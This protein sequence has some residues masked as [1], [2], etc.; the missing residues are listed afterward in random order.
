MVNGNHLQGMMKWIQED[1]ERD[2]SQAE[3]GK[4]ALVV[5]NGGDDE[6][7]GDADSFELAC[8]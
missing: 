6:N 3:Y 5:G 1:A 8:M 2:Y 7:S 4:N